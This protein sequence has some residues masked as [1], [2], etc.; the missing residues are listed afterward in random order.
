[1][2]VH[3]ASQIIRDADVERAMVAFDQGLLCADSVDLV[4]H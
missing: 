4:G 3:T 2:L 1:M